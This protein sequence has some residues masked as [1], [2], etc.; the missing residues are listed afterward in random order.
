MDP[1]IVHVT[2][3]SM[4][5]ELA[6]VPDNARKLAKAFWPGPLTLVLKKRPIVPDLITAG[7]DT[8]AIRIPR[9]PVAADLLRELQAPLAAPSANPFGY[10]S[11]TR[12]EHVT[13]AFGAK[14]PF[15]LDGGPSE[16]GLESS[17]LDMSGDASLSILRPGAIAAQEISAVLQRPVETRTLRLKETEAATAPGTML[18]HYSPRTPL[19]P[20]ETGGIPEQRETDAIVF[21]KRP[22]EDQTD[23]SRSCYWLS[24]DG[25]MGQVGQSLFALIRQLDQKGY[26]RILC[27]LPSVE[28]SGIAA[29]VRD[30]L[31]RAAAKK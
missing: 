16:V 28:S 4:A 21:L 31:T 29:A 10:V 25:S 8:V 15:V 23:P 18:R 1:L 19:V 9:H 11:P 3:L 5:E 14:V 20:F 7:M 13:S 12:P 2:D 6:V 30:R 24:E 17:I 26:S 22:G 27:E